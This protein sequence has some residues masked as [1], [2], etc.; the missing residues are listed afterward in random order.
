MYMYIIL[1]CHSEGGT[2]AR[3]TRHSFNQWHVYA[4]FGGNSVNPLLYTVYYVILVKVYTAVYNRPQIYKT[5]KKLTV[6]FK[7]LN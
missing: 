2:K 1:K 5:Y 6:Y 3:E 4:K 7:T